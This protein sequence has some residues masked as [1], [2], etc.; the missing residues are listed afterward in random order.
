MGT[1]RFGLDAPAVPYHWCAS[2]NQRENLRMQVHHA[3]TQ[4]D[5]HLH[6]HVHLQHAFEVAY[7]N[8]YL[9]RTRTYAFEDAWRPCERAYVCRICSVVYVI[10]I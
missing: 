1:K 6:T 4:L 2:T 7:T 5:E 10:S 3:R 8:I 9:R